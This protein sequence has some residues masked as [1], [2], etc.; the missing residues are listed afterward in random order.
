M[1][2]RL[3]TVLLLLGIALLDSRLG[4]LFCD[5]FG[6]SVIGI[7]E[8]VITSGLAPCKYAVLTL[9]ISV[10]TLWESIIAR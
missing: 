9:G 4:K 6:K 7:R 2:L 1:L 3:G 5:Y 8:S 10:L